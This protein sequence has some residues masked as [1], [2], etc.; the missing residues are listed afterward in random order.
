MR[1]QVFEEKYWS[2]YQ[3]LEREFLNTVDYVTIDPMNYKAFSTKYSSLIL[4][5][6]SEIDVVSKLLSYLLTK[7][8]GRTIYQSFRNI[9]YNYPYTSSELSQMEV[10]ILGHDNFYIKPW[11]ELD[12]ILGTFPF[13][14][15]NYNLLKHHRQTDDNY[16]HGNL[17]TCLFALAALFIIELIL[18]RLISENDGEKTLLMPQY[19]S[20]IFKIQNW[21][22]HAFNFNG[23][24]IKE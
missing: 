10:R 8:T 13:W 15:G 6:C 4:S 23:V 17:E 18:Y 14:W 24:I 16:I 12:I 9:L 11:I 7:K 22:A 5:I 2:Y 19:P 3:F 1:I 20:Q 21:V